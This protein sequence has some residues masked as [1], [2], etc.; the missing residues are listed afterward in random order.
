MEITYPDAAWQMS[1]ASGAC[2]PQKL[3]I[4]S[5]TAF[6]FLHCRIDSASDDAVASPKIHPYHR[7]GCAIY[8][9]SGDFTLTGNSAVPFHQISRLAANT[10]RMT[11]DFIWPKNQP[12]KNGIEIG[13]VVLSAQWQRF[14]IL[15]AGQASLEWH[16]LPAPADPPVEI[17]PLSALILFERE[18]GLRL[19]MGLGDDLWRWQHGFNSES[20][21]GHGKLEIAPNNGRFILRRW[22]TQ[23]PPVP[24]PPRQPLRQV[25]GAHGK[26]PSSAPVLFIPEAR[27]Y[28]FNSYIAWS[29]PALAPDAN[30]FDNL[31]VLDCS[32]IGGLKRS[33]LEQCGANPAL[34]I[35]LRQ[36]PLPPSNRRSSAD[37]PC[38]CARASQRLYRRLIRQIAQYSSRGILRIDGLTPGWCQCASH[39]NRRKNADHWDLCA[40]LD[41]AIW[42]RQLLGDGWQLHFPQTGVW[43]E[44]PSLQCLGAPSG[45]RIPGTA[46]VSEDEEEL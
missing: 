28:R 20:L 29:S 41:T 10:M 23:C 26:I 5:K 16:A 3:L 18:D 34:A 9:G 17:S 27:P 40:I 14:A 39:A 22:V 43:G 24:A 13:S 45:F 37:A 36:L 1:A 11:T 7:G 35:D 33:E 44:L 42:T 12:L 32:G 8:E 38:W 6:S 2:A 21:K 25:P 46:E 31:T 15:P 19:E 30:A 4:D